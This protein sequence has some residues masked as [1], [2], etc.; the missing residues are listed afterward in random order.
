MRK[1]EKIQ[2]LL[3]GI[4][5]S[6]ADPNTCRVTLHAIGTDDILSITIGAFEGRAIYMG[7]KGIQQN[8]PMTHDLFSAVLGA[9]SVKLWRMVIYRVE[10]GVFYSYLYFQKDFSVMRVDARTSDALALAV[11]MSAPIFTYKELLE[12]ALIGKDCFIR[13]EDDLNEFKDIEVI[14]PGID[15]LKKELDEA[16]AKENYE[17]AAKLRDQLKELGYDKP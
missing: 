14:T 16:I 12:N 7:A 13:V 5:S 10:N 6:G 9:M 1:N 2:L 17:K 3:D 11:R 4:N 15:S 8:R